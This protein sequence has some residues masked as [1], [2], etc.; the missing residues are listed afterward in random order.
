MDFVSTL[1][2]F[3]FIGAV[4]VG[5]YLTVSAIYWFIKYMWVR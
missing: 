3:V 5:L 1:L 2:W 4:F